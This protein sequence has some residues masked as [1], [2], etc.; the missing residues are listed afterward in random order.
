[1]HIHHDCAE[2]FYVLDGEYVIFLGD[3]EHSSPRDRSSMSPLEHPT[4]SGLARCLAG[5]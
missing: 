5:S 2:A 4:D 1:M 3:R